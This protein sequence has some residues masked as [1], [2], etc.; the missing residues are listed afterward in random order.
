M[1]RFERRIW[2]VI[3]AQEFFDAAFLAADFR[4]V[5]SNPTTPISGGFLAESP[6]KHL[7][8]S[9]KN[10]TLNP[11]SE[12]PPVSALAKRPS[13]QARSP[14]LIIEPFLC[15]KLI[16][17]QAQTVPPSN[18]PR[19]NLRQM[20]SDSTALRSYPL[21]CHFWQCCCPHCNIDHHHHHHHHPTTTITTPPPSPPPPPPPLSHTPQRSPS[22][23]PP[24]SSPWT[25]FK[26]C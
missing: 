15:V 3:C 21:R 22:P 16:V 2:R 7:S 23:A 4:C 5:N 19:K 24:T 26:T 11:Q 13:I 18:F 1:F 20:L 8:L 9:L 10:K 12:R 14:P 6:S 25:K 17:S